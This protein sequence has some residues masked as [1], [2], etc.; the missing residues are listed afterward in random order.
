MPKQKKKSDEAGINMDVMMDSMTNVVGTLLLILIV[1][2]I[3]ISTAVETIETVL[4]NITQKDLQNLSAKI[5]EQNKNLK[6]VDVDAIDEAYRKAMGD[7]DE[8]QLRVNIY[9]QEVKQK[10]KNGLLDVQEL[11]EMKAEKAAEVEIEQNIF[12]E[13]SRERQ[14]L[15]ALLAKT[16][17]PKIPAGADIVVPA[18][19]PMPKSPKYVK[20]MCRYNRLYYIQDT[21]Y[22]E[23]AERMMEPKMQSMIYSNYIDQKTKRPMV[24]YDHMKVSGLLSTVASNLDVGNTNFVIKHYRDDYHN[25]V[26]IHLQPDPKGGI[27]LADLEER[28]NQFRKD[29]IRIKRDPKNVIWFYVYKDSLDVYLKARDICQALGAPQGWEFYRWTAF[30]RDLKYLV[31]RLKIRTNRV[32]RVEGRKRSSA[33]QIAGPKKTLD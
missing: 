29:V 8:A 14:R 5:A 18:G 3:Q 28:N 27:S 6:N 1:V 31:N 20:I 15:E 24:I 21:Q 17:K 16:P 4:K 30:G 7:V 25:R 23:L 32:S 11:I 13:L 19:L 9:A 2:Q 26:R 10:S 22:K 33:I 12:N